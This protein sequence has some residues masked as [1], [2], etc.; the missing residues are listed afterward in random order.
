[1]SDTIKKKELTCDSC[2]KIDYVLF[3]GYPFGDRMLEDVYFRA[4]PNETM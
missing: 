3:E 2:G 1:M 4:T